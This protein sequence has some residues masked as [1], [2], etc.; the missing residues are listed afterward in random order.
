[1]AWGSNNPKK[2][3]KLRMSKCLIPVQLFPDGNVGDAKAARFWNGNPR[4][5]RKRVQC[6]YN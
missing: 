1:M 5:L 2:E 3:W 6:R 4:F